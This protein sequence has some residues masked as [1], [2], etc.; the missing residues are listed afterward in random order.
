MI[1]HKIKHQIFYF[2]YIASFIILKTFF[3]IS[4]MLCAFDFNI[5]NN[6]KTEIKREEI[7][8]SNTNLSTTTPNESNILSSILASNSLSLYTT[9]NTNP[10]NTIKVVGHIES[11]Y[12]ERVSMRILEVLSPATSTIPISVGS[13]ISFNLPKNV[14]SKGKK[15][16]QTIEYGNIVEVEL[17]G[18][19]TTE[20][21]QMQNGINSNNTLSKSDHIQVPDVKIWLA[22][23]I[24]KLKKIDKYIDMLPDDGTNKIKRKHNKKQKKESE[25][26]QI[27]TQEEVVKG[28]VIS[29]KGKFYI[30]ESRSRPKDL[31]L[32]ITDQTWEEKLTPYLNKTLVIYG[33]TH[34][35][36]ISSG[37]IEIRNILKIYN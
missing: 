27:W 35:S 24:Q 5:N 23:K 19:T 32:L 37:T 4:T 30:K 11:L 26:P 7:T 36:T 34:R 31:G 16:N 29:S 12:K 20:Y 8:K 14:L 33:I 17:E 10:N 25:P 1:F 3:S 21:E 2:I 22:K 9:Y 15:K 13:R 6:I 18:I 28:K